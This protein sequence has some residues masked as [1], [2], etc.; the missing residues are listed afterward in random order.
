MLLTVLMITVFTG[1]A[2]TFAVAKDNQRSTTLEFYAEEGLSMWNFIVLES[3][4]EGSVVHMRAYKSAS[5]E[6]TIEGIGAFLG[7]DEEI[8]PGGSYDELDLHVKMF[9]TGKVIS[10]GKVTMYIFCENGD[11][12]T[13]YGTVIA[14]QKALG[15]PFE[16]KYVLQGTGD[17]E[18]M[19]LFGTVW[20]IGGIVNGLAGTILIPN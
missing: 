2:C 19:K 11:E 14:K 3:W 6:G 15:E 8:N 13:F 9:A 16:G 20:V 12:G 18:G 10:I 17:F 4:G 1:F 5:L 7:Y